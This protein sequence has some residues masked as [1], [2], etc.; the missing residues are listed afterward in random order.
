MSWDSVLKLA[1]FAAG[2]MVVLQLVFYVLFEIIGYDSHLLSIPLI[3]SLIVAFVF[4]L[5]W[6]IAKRRL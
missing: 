6:N 2:V 4:L 1:V 3:V 5:L